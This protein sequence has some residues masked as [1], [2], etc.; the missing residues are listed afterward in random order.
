MKKLLFVFIFSCVLFSCKTSQLTLSVTEPAPVTLPREIRKVGVINRSI[1]TDE[2]KLLD[3]IDKALSLEGADL[4]RDGAEQCVKG[5]TEELMTNRRFDEVR[6]LAEIDFR[7]PKLGNIFPVP[8]SWEIVDKIAEEQEI[9]ALFSLDYFDTEARVNYSTGRTDIK[10]PGGI[11]VPAVEH[12]AEME[13]IVRTGWRIYCPADRLIADEY[14]DL[15]SVKYSGRGVSPLVAVAGLIKR[16]DAIMEVSR[17]AGHDYALR[18]IPFS[19]R[20]SREYFVRGTDNFRIARRKAQA[21]QWEEAGMLW[22][23]ETSGSRPKIAGRACHNMGIISEI[24]GDVKLAL[25]WAQ[26]AYG[27]YNIKKSLNY[28][29]ILENRIRKAD[30]LEYQKIQ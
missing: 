4:D 7:T 15:Q 30:L 9:D 3:I 20:V 18:L 28:V 26:K 16:K 21:G 2:T 12:R 29:R 24:N 17:L 23:K 8:L 5:L 14:H 6:N 27:D 22:E 1:P 11:V 25:S 19:R 10:A 13:T